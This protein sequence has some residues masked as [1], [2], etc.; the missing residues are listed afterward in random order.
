[1]Q[2]ALCYASAVFCASILADSNR[3]RDLDPSFQ[4]AILYTNRR[5]R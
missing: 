4:L 1:M 2:V 3:S 5:Y